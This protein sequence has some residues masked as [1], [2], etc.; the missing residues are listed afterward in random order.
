MTKI[1]ELLGPNTIKAELFSEYQWVSTI[2]TYYTRLVL[3]SQPKDKRYLEQYFNKTIKYI[4]KTTELEEIQK[5]LPILEFD[6]EY[7][8]KLEQY[9]KNKEEK[10]ANIVFTLNRFVLVDKF[11]NPVSESLSEKV[12]RLLE[13]WKEKTKDYEKI[14]QEGIKVIKEF[15]QLSER[16]KK[17]NLTKLD[18]SLLLVL[19]DKFGEETELVDDIRGLSG[20]LKEL[21]FSG[22]ISQPTAQK[23]VEK[24]VRL[25]LRKYIKRYDLAIDDLNSLFNKLMDRVKAYA[26]ED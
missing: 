1:F 6:E 22:W 3:R 21:L 10:A 24:T 8:R 25:F 11:K 13:L 17:L 16:Q 4:H 23:E 14:Y 5:S 12:Q 18:Y 20:S 2:H 26:K 9:V 7:F 19:E 15:M